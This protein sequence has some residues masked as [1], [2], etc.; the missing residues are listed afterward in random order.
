MRM[1][2]Q[3]RP[4]EKFVASGLYQIYNHHDNIAA[5]FEEWSIHEQPDG[6]QI[7]RAD[8]LDGKKSSSKGSLIEVLRS[9]TSDFWQTERYYYYLYTPKG[10]LK[11]NIIFSENLAQI[12]RE[13]NHETEVF[14]YALPDDCLIAA[15][16]AACRDYIT[17]LRVGKENA[18]PVFMMSELEPSVMGYYLL[19]QP[20]AENVKVGTEILNGTGY[21]SIDKEFR[22]LLNMT[23]STFDAYGNLIKQSMFAF[24]VTLSRY[25][26]RPEPKP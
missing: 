6:S 7:I 24:E 4:H 20:E 11:E 16:C 13:K 14:E 8:N 17:Q 12:V 1:I 3:V 23:D 2:H 21:T 26:H 9:K 25:A 15:P 22:D 18:R 19:R 5:G 10:L